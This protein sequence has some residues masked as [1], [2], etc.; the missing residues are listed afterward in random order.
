[1][2]QPRL[3]GDYIWRL[4]RRTPYVVPRS[5]GHGYRVRV[6]WSDKLG[7]QL[8]HT[9]FDEARAQ[10]IVEQIRLRGRLDMT[11]WKKIYRPK[12]TPTCRTVRS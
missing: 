8:D 5:D 12:W 6:R 10:R 11:C 1:M 9:F 4:G 2:K 3:F 7:L